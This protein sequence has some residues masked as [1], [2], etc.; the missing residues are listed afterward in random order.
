M[1]PAITNIFNIPLALAIG[2]GIGTAFTYVMVRIGFW[3][4]KHKDD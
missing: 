1:D 3:I 4:D 2:F